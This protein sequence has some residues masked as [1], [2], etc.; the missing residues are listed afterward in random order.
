MKSIFEEMG[1]T[2]T[3]GEDRTF[4]FIGTSLF[5]DEPIQVLADIVKKGIYFHSFR[6][7]SMMHHFADEGH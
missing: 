2:Y 6:G 5:N 7:A 4:L 1:G 3:P